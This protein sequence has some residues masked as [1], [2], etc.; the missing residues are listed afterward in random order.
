MSSVWARLA[1]LGVALEAFASRKAGTSLTNCT[2]ETGLVLASEETDYSKAWTDPLP[3]TKALVGL[4]LLDLGRRDCLSN[5]SNYCFGNSADFCSDC[6][7]CCVDGNY[8]C[9]RG[10]VCCGSGCCS[11]GETCSQGKCLSSV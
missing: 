2:S 6:G 1:V 11:S 3:G 10:K 9:G 7:N 4:Q 8:C 5:G